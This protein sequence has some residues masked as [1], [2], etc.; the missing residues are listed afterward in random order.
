MTSNIAP[1]TFDVLTKIRGVQRSRKTAGEHCEMCAEQITDD[2][3]HVVNTTA[4][5]L[6]CVCRGCYLLFTNQDAALRYRAVPDRFLAFPN[7]AL[8]W[9]EWETLQIPVG[10]AFFFYNSELQR[11][12]AFYPGPAGAIQSEL[13]ISTWATVSA[14]P[15]VNLLADDVEALLVKASDSTSLQC[16][17]VPIDTC[18]EFSGQLRLV[19]RGFDGGAQAHK[20]IDNF[21]TSI[22]QRAKV[23]L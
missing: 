21:F 10:F 11:T 5:Q 17:L 2:H 15:R 13:D 14:D 4:R 22:A 18:Y 8:S 1:G 7:F 23:Y 12:V 20:Y 3:R 6:L 9:Q 19:W 16:F